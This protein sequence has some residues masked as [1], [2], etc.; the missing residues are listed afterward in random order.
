MGATAA[1]VGGI[2][3]VIPNLPPFVT[4]TSL[5]NVTLTEDAWTSDNI[6]LWGSDPN[7]YHQANLQVKLLSVPE[8]VTLTLGNDTTGANIITIDQLPLL[9][10]TTGETNYTS[11]SVNIF[12]IVGFSGTTTFTFEVVDALGLISPV[13]VV[14]ITIIHVNHAPTCRDEDLYVY[15]NFCIFP[16][17]GAPQDVTGYRHVEF[18]GQD[19]DFDEADSLTLVWLNITDPDTIGDLAYYPTGSPD[20]TNLTT[21]VNVTKPTA[22]DYWF[23]PIHNLRSV[24]TDGTD[25][26]T[27]APVTTVSFM[28]VD[29][30]DASSSVCNLNIY[31]T[32]VNQPPTCED[33][34]FTI[35]ENSEL[36]VYFYDSPNGTTPHYYLP[37]FDIDN[38]DDQLGAQAVG[39]VEGSGGTWYTI[40]NQTVTDSGATD[41]PGYR[42]LRFVPDLNTFSLSGQIYSTL[43]YETY[44][45]QPLYSDP[46]EIV[47]FVSHIC[48][49]VYWTG[50]T[51]VRT[52]EDTPVM[53]N[54]DIPAYWSTPDPGVGRITIL[55]GPPKGYMYEC[56]DV[57]CTNITSYPHLTNGPFFY[58]PP[59]NDNGDNYTSFD[60]ELMILDPLGNDCP[61]ANITLTYWIDITPVDDP[62]TLIPLWL[63]EDG[64]ENACPEDTFLKLRWT[65]E[66]IDNTCDQLSSQILNL[67]QHTSATLYQ[68]NSTNNVNGTGAF[69]CSDNNAITTIEYINQ[70]TKLNLVPGAINCTSGNV[71]WEISVIGFPN[72]NGNLRLYLVIWDPERYSEQESALVTFWPVNDP[73]SIVKTKTRIDI[74]KYSFHNATDGGYYLIGTAL[75]GVNF[76]IYDDLAVDERT[77]EGENVY[78]DSQRT[79]LQQEATPTIVQNLNSSEVLIYRV[80]TQVQDVD[81]YFGHTLGIYGRII[82]GFW[83]NPNDLVRTIIQ[84]AGV[85]CNITSNE[86]N[87]T[88]IIGPFNIWLTNVGFPFVFL[89]ESTTGYGLFTL[90]DFGNIDRWDRPL[91]TNFTIAWYA[92]PPDNSYSVPIAAIAI[93]PIVA[94]ATAAYRCCLGIPRTTCS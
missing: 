67:V 4:N 7:W 90:Y 47:V 89:N 54:L 86:L 32:P 93:L 8:G 81:F 83:V 84:S 31:V 58:V 66:D 79:R 24:C 19:P 15:Q 45:Q 3:A 78:S 20:I 1:S 62:P 2:V 60:F 74:E 38:T 71:Y 34:S 14:N 36:I 43:Y 56:T 92:P 87:C 75:G 25:P 29:I 72:W 26:S 9:L 35:D 52:L 39:I 85:D 91:E 12:P 22:W 94:A 21:V 63:T 37:A 61:G 51:R 41:L 44:D 57:S 77:L 33:L 73:P 82:N 16:D 88:G 48:I 40:N 69:N 80:R 10:P 11:S 49:P 64:L 55:T 6:P 46:C 50:P 23:Q 65:A 59:A 68:C 76:T 70:T 27:C 42:Y 17:C 13:Q 53:I 18:L 28:V 30:N 5:Y